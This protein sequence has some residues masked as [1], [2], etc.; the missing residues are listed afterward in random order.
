MIY[1]SNFVI[2]NRLRQG[3]LEHGCGKNHGLPRKMIYQCW[4]VNIYVGF[5][6]IQDGAPKIAKLVYKWFNY[7]LW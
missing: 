2:S 4:I 5:G 7:G 1:L 3:K 6:P